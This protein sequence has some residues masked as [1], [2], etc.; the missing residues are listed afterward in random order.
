MLKLNL[1]SLG[2]FV[3]L[4]SQTIVAL[5][6]D[7]VNLHYHLSAG[8]GKSDRSDRRPVTENA[9]WDDMPSSKKMRFTA[10]RK[11]ARDSALIALIVSGALNSLD[12]W[13]R[14][15]DLGFVCAG[16][17][18]FLGV[19]L[20]FQVIDVPLAYYRA[21]GLGEEGKRP[22]ERAN[23]WI[24]NLLRESAPRV[25]VILF[26][27][28]ALLLM[29]ELS[30]DWWWLWCLPAGIAL[31]FYLTVLY[32]SVIE[33][34][35]IRAEVISD[36]ALLKELTSLT[37]RAGL[38]G[39]SFFRIPGPV[40]AQHAPYCAG[41]GTIRGIFL[42]DR[43]LS[44]LDREETLALVAHEIGH[45]RK[46]HI[47]VT[48]AL[49]SVVT[50]FVLLCTFLLARWDFLKETFGLAPTSLYPS[51][52]LIAVFWRKLGFFL[53]PAYMGMLRQFELQADRFAAEL[54]G[55][56][57]PVASALTKIAE[58]DENVSHSHPVYQR[59]HGSHPP[60]QVRVASLRNQG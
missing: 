26:L 17:F 46:R 44:I 22:M 3:I 52:F 39:V 15:L 7:W 33:P 18:F 2:F 5:L 55:T 36:A 24:A 57:S 34:H 37:Q 28:C 40:H 45:F 14:G 4:I 56:A 32:P 35:S 47:L 38:P 13:I 23:S 10:V 59:F 60:F 49:G 58:K 51:L 43:M 30:P 11:L 29:I 25:L 8:H 42:P 9:A 12:L 48:F 20:F 31:Q 16:V 1:L 27:S 6:I 21:R 50:F 19:V 41:L 54:M 53:K